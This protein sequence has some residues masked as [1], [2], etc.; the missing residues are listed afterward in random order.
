[1]KVAEIIAEAEG[2]RKTIRTTTNVSVRE[3]AMGK[4]LA[5][6]EVHPFVGVPGLDGPRLAAKRAHLYEVERSIEVAEGKREGGSPALGQRLRDLKSER[7]YLT[8]SVLAEENHIM[9]TL[10]G[11]E[12]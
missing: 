2:H 5:L 10:E 9:A 6:A 11:V 4:I 12:A 8:R 1:M 7:A 3:A